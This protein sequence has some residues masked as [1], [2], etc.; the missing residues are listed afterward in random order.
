MDLLLRFWDNELN[1]VVTRYFDSMFLGHTRAADL[2]EKFKG[3]FSKLN[4]SNMLQ[5]SMDGPSINWKFMDLLQQDRSES[6]P[7][8]TS[9]INIGSCGLHVVHGAFKHG[10]IKAGWKLDGVFRSLYHCFH[11]SPA[12]REDYVAANDGSALFG[13]KFCATRWLKDVPVAERAIQIWPNGQKYIA[14]TQI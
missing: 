5:V 12:R 8:I 14:S 7:N 2:L 4:L 11:D 1:R 10:A 3:G 6:D 13:L 9:L